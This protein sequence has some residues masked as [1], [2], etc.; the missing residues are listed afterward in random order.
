MDFRWISEKILDEI[1]SILSRVDEK[2]VEQLVDAILSSERIFV[3]GLGRSGL[4]ARS[5]AI[6]LMHLG[7]KVLIVGDMTT[8]AIKSGDLLVAI[9][10]SGETPIIQ[11]IVTKAKESDATIFL[12]TAKSETGIND[13]C[14][15]MLTLPEVNERVLPLRSAFEASAYILLDTAIIM[16]MDRTGVTQKEMMERHSNLE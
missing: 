4:V 11:H 1:N 13:L 10:G 14:N 3:T 2:K 5:F 15:C 12:V 6:R 16:I 8:P 9:S 7:L